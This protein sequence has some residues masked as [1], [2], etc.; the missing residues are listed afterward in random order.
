MD[1]PIS[2]IKPFYHPN[3][4][5]PNESPAIQQTITVLDLQPHIEGGFFVVTDENPLRIPNPFPRDSSSCAPPDDPTDTTRAASTCIFYFL[6]PRAPLGTF[7]RNKA[8]TVH[9]LHRGRG[10][11]VILHA[12][13][14]GED[15]GR[16]VR[17][18][19]F[20][21]GRNLAAGERLQWIVEGGKYKSSYLLPDEDGDGEAETEGLLISEVGGFCYSLLVLF[22]S[23]RFAHLSMSISR[24]LFPGLNTVTTISCVGMRWIDW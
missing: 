10:R 22:I 5:P 12:D 21:V 13:E 3:T 15:G 20:V 7:H 1:I 4:P 6:A 16:K 23:S 11:Y 9:T 24:P 2:K 18:E 19:S 14:A 17:V 8:R